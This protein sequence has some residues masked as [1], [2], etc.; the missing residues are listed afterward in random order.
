MQFHSFIISVFLT[1]RLLFTPCSVSIIIYYVI[2][3]GHMY[4]NALIHNVTMPP[5]WEITK[6]HRREG[7]AITKIHLRVPCKLKTSAL[8]LGDS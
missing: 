7:E 5:N 3:M 6:L 2:P 4:N 8:P 1:H